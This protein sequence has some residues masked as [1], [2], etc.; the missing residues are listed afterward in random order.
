V[1]DEWPPRE[2]RVRAGLWEAEGCLERREYFAATQALARIFGLAGADEERVRGLHHLAAAG[3][4]A[5]TGDLRS[6][7]RQLDH[8]RRRLAGFADT[9]PLIGLVEE[10]I[11]STGGEL[12]QP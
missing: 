1:D 11:G 8:A 7:H 10:D 4:K 5:Q 6:A 9:A 3:Y 12:A 2:N